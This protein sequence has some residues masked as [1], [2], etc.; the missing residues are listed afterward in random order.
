[1]RSKATGAYRMALPPGVY[2]VATREKVGIDRTIR[3]HLVHVRRG[4][5]DKLNFFID[6]G[7]R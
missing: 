7:I 6:T 2:T 1:M 5:W 3:P 4:H